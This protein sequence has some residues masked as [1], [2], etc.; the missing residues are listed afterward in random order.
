MKSEWIYSNLGYLYA[1]AAAILP[2]FRV[3]VLKALKAHAA[4]LCPSMQITCSGKGYEQHVGI[5]LPL[6]DS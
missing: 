4:P 3:L 2:Y 6:G 1:T 5:L